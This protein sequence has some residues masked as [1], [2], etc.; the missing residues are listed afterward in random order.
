MID[1]EYFIVCRPRE[2]EKRFDLLPI[3]GP[4]E[5]TQSIP[6]HT[7]PLPVGHK[8][9]I[10][11]NAAKPMRDR[12]GKT[13]IKNTPEILFDGFNPLVRGG[14]REKILALDL[15]NIFFQPS[16]YIDDWGVW[17]EDYWYVSF[18]E[19]FDHWDRIKSD[20]GEKVRVAGEYLHEVYRVGLD[21]PVLRKMPMKDR[22]IFQ[23]KALSSFVIAH[24]S[25][26][27]IFKL[28]GALVVSLGDYPNRP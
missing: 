17:H 12:R 11:D 8:P 23:I 18:L 2:D 7:E 27:S 21:E 5:D 24:Q 6:Y 10:F 9:L 16:V 26:A 25:V 22:M 13:T 15:P 1:N 19:K 4:D 20:V 3:L 28:S 14:V